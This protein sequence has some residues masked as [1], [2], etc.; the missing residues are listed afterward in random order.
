MED[1]Q[2][3]S[4]YTYNG[5][6]EGNIL[7]VGRTGYGKTTFIQGLGKN[8]LFGSEITDAFWVLKIVLSKER[9]DFIRDSFEEQE[10]H[11][12]YPHDFNY[13]GQNFS[14]DKS[15][16]IESEMGEE[17]TVNRL[18][19]MDDVSGLDDK[20]E[21]FSNFLTVSKKYGF[22]CFYVFHTIYPGRQSWEMIISQAHIF[23]FFRGSIHSSRILKTLSIFASRQKNTYLPNQQA[24]LNKFYFQ[25]SN[26]KEKQCLTL[27]TREINELGPGKFSTYANDRE[28]QTCYFNRKKSD[29]HFTSFLA[30][31][32]RTKPITFSIVKVN[33]NF[34]LVNKSLDIELNSSLP[35]GRV[36]RQ[37]QEISAENLNNGRPKADILAAESRTEP[38]RQQHRGDQRG[39]FGRK[40]VRKKSRFIE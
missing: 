2:Y 26:S 17:L 21:V 37:F 11:F 28:E 3:N 29:T 19:I 27:D 23:N 38:G 36:K 32:T 12:S 20:S 6:F 31:W 24:W 4:V 40:P 22:S 8:K 33:T 34:E 1:N 10:L 5:K 7:V 15:E 9:E 13:L 16:Y 35:D 18:I 14:Q 25:I 39:N 30:K